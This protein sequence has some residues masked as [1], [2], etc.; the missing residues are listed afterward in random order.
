[1]NRNQ[2]FIAS[3]SS[4]LAPPVHD[5]MPRWTIAVMSVLTAARFLVSKAESHDVIKHGKQSGDQLIAPPSHARS[6]SREVRSPADSLMK[7]VM[8]RPDLV[9]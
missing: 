2:Y 5:V 1:V 3:E 9:L 7:R 4:V 8:G 6:S